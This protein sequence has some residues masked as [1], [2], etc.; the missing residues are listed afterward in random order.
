MAMGIPVLHGVLGE[1]AEIVSRLGVGKT[2]APDHPQVMAQ[3]ILHLAMNN[4][5]LQQIKE[6]ALKAA[7]QFDRKHLA[8][9]MLVSIAKFAKT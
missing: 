1:S 2:I 9:S 5:E 3:E 7:N 4:S 8:Q 6:A